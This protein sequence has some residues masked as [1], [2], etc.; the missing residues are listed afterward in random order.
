MVKTDPGLQNKQMQTKI[1]SFY[2]FSPVKRTRYEI[3]QKKLDGIIETW[4]TNKIRTAPCHV[5]L[6]R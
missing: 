4:P 6:F 2:G 1:Q 3:L 5:A